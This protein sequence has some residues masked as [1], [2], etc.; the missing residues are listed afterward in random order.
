MKNI[1]KNVL[2]YG[3]EQDLPLQKVLYAGALSMIYEEG[4]LRRIKFGNHEVIRS[5]YVAVR[6][7]N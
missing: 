5:A 7:Q 2:R 1:S 4:T 6:N 3:N